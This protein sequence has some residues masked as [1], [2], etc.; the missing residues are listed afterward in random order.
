MNKIT[1][2]LFHKCIDDDNFYTL[3]YYCYNS[4]K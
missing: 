1:F 4:K 2:H 3:K